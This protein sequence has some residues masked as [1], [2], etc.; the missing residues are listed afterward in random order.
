MLSNTYSYNILLLTQHKGGEG[1]YSV[2]ALGYDN[3]DWVQQG[4]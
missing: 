1:I 3:T 4:P 2:L